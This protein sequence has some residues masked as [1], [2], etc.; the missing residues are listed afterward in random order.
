MEPHPAT[1]APDL[2]QMLDMLIVVS[3]LI[4]SAN[5]VD[6]PQRQPYGQLVAHLDTTL[7]AEAK[8][9][10]MLLHRLMDDTLVLDRN[11]RDMLRELLLTLLH[12]AK[13]L[14]RGLCIVVL[15]L[16]LGGSP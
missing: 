9:H 16:L 6:H 12:H 11:G 10:L 15:G 4:G 1:A 14:Q 7:G 13:A 2:E 5:G 8:H 3:H